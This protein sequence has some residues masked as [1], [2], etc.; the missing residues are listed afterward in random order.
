M[1]LAG[2]ELKPVFTLGFGFDFG[3]DPNNGISA[4]NNITY[5]TGSYV[6]ETYTSVNGQD[7]S[8]TKVEFDARRLTLNPTINLAMD[9]DLSPGTGPSLVLWGKFG[10]HGKNYGVTTKTTN[11]FFAPNQTHIEEVKTGAFSEW[12]DSAFTL[13]PGYR[14]TLSLG[15]KVELG[16]RGDVELS[17]KTTNRKPDNSTVTI[18]RFEYPNPALNYTQTVTAYSAGTH[19]ETSKFGITPTAKAAFRYNAIPGRLTLNAGVGLTLPAF[20]TETTKQSPLQSKTV[21][22]TEYIDG[23]RTESV[24]GTT[25]NGSDT[26]TVANTWGAFGWNF[27]AG[28]SFLFNE[29]FGADLAF[30]GNNFTNLNISTLRVL[31]TVRK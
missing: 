2:G 9:L 20:S 6:Y 27:G 26:N 12:S 19:Q 14:R 29:N 23:T 5:G 28:F 24:T 25:F 22:L 31:F 4:S 11:Y 8:R 10:F 7:T 16:L 13:T 18:D 15:D 30:G 3:S 17:F 1:P 21:T